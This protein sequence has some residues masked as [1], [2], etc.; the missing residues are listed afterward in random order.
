MIYLQLF[1]EFFKTGLFAI[2]GG[3]ATLPFLYDMSDKLAW[4]SHSDIANMVALSES[5]PGPIGV[6]MATFAGFQTAGVLG[7]I[8][9]T[10]GLMM[11]SVI[12]ILSIAKF[13]K[14]YQRN[15][16]MLGAFYGL[17]PASAGLIAA[18]CYGVMRVALLN[19]DVYHQTGKLLDLF[20]YKAIA[21]AAVI[22]LFTHIK[23]LKNLHPVIFLI[24]SAA[25][26][27]LL[28]F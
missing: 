18:A 8:V 15:R 22:L 2:G 7:G 4:F 6:N 5:T 11:P 1:F 26:G 21:L 20:H 25:I 13:L 16:Y 10:L 19:T 17:R 14:T 27:I 3:L 23:P 12:I 28:K 24:F 9:A